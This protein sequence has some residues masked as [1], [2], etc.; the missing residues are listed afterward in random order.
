[1]KNE[2]RILKL[3]KYEYGLVFDS[4]ND[5]RNELLK[6]NESTDFIDDVLIKVV[7]AP[8]RSRR[9]KEHER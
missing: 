9:D 7:N 1:M 4:L 3:D 2:K 6:S 5:K 8:S